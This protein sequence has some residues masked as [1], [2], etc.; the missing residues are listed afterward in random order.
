[1]KKQNK[2]HLNRFYHAKKYIKLTS[3]LVELKELY[4]QLLTRIGGMKNDW[5]G[6]RSKN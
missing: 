2:N 6:N 4:N 5:I 3:D 1:M